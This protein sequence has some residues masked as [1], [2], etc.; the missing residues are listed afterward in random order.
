MNLREVMYDPVSKMESKTQNKDSQSCRKGAA[1]L[2]TTHNEF[3]VKI[4]GSTEPRHPTPPLNPTPT[5][6]SPSFLLPISSV[7]S[8]RLSIVLCKHRCNFFSGERFCSREIV[9]VH[10]EIAL[11][12]SAPLF[13]TVPSTWPLSLSLWSILDEKFPVE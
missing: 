5:P 3:Q 10:C 4:L 11:Y 8:F 2:K 1:S 9:L 13:V 7:E 6:T 12:I